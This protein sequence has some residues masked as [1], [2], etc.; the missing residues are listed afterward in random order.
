MSSSY[1]HSKHPQNELSLP[2]L[3][4][5]ADKA[6]LVDAI[7]AAR[8][9]HRWRSD[10]AGSKQA[11]GSVFPMQPA[12]PASDGADGSAADAQ[13]GCYFALRQLT[14]FQQTIDFSNGRNGKHG[15]TDEDLECEMEVLR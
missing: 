3:T 12:A 7:A 10:T 14:L 11:V 9:A 5:V 1:V 2:M 8:A 15:A 4:P 6:W 13:P